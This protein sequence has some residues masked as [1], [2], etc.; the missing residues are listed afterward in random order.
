[1][2]VV[3]NNTSMQ[4]TGD[5]LSQIDLKSVCCEELGV[6][7]NVKQIPV[8]MAYRKTTAHLSDLRAASA[9]VTDLMEKVNDQEWK[10][11]HVFYR[12][13]TLFY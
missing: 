12:N 10:N 5:I 11:H 1:M 6:T 13:T 3:I 8:E 9:S 2:E 4:I 7:I